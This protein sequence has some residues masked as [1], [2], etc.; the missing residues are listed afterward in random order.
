MKP[1][2]LREFA[3]Q[4]R[5]TENGDFADQISD[6][7]DVVEEI[8]SRYDRDVDCKLVLRLW[9]ILGYRTEKRRADFI[10]QAYRSQVLDLPEY[11]L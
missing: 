3:E 11:E 2:D 10:N 4:L 8:E 6:N 9:K 1:L 7:L 5:L